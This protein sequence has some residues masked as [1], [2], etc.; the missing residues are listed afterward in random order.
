MSVDTTQTK[1]Q[2]EKSIIEKITSNSITGTS[3]GKARENRVG[4][5]FEE[6]KTKDFSKDLFF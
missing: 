4:E 5:I 3:E 6:M 1:T 2:G